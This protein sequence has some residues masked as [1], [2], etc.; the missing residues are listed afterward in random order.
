[1]KCEI[2][3]H[4]MSNIIDATY[5]GQYDQLECPVCYQIFSNAYDKVMIEVD[6]ERI[7]MA[8]TAFDELSDVIEYELRSAR[9]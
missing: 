7:T 5:I 2:A 1:M 9:L 8:F 4:I 6:Q 3:S